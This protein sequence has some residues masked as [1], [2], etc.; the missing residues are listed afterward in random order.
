MIFVEIL[1][2]RLVGLQTEQEDGLLGWIPAWFQVNSLCLSVFL[3]LCL[4]ISSLGHV[5][6]WTFNLSLTLSVSHCLAVLSLLSFSLCSVILLSTTLFLIRKCE[7]GLT[8]DC[9]D[10]LKWCNCDSGRD[11]WLYD[12]GELK[13]HSTAQWKAIH[14][15]VVPI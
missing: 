1:P 12:G 9:Y 10:V 7:C 3:S 15:L 6:E 8:G 2:I 11:D 14:E 5:S 4:S 13:V